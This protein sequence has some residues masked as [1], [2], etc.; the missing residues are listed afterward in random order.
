MTNFGPL[1]TPDP[2]QVYNYG[3]LMNFRNPTLLG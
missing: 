3:P 2:G 1:E